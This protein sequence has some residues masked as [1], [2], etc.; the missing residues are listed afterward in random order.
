VS[1]RH[2]VLIVALVAI[3]IAILIWQRG[4]GTPTSSKTTAERERVAKV[5]RGSAGDA[6]LAWYARGARRRIAGVVLDETKP[7]A[8]ATVRLASR[9]AMAGVMPELR[10]VS[11][12]NGRFEFPPQLPLEYLVSAELPQRTTAFASVDL[13]SPASAEDLHLVLHACEA[14]LHGTIR[15]AAGGVI[16]HARVALAE[17]ELSTSA[18]AEADDGGKYELCVPVGAAIVIASADGYADAVDY[19]TA[20]GPVQRDFSLVPEATVAGKVVLATDRSPVANAVVELRAEGR[21]DRP[22]RTR[23]AVSDASGAFHFD[24]ATPGSYAIIAKADGLVSTR[25]TYVIAEAEAPLEDIVCVVGPSATVSGKVVERGGKPVAGSVLVLRPIAIEHAAMLAQH[26]A[27]TEP[28]GTFAIEHVLPGTYAPWVTLGDL[29]DDAKRIVVV[30]ADVSNVVLEIERGG[31]ISGRVTSRGKPVEGAQVNV[32]GASTVRFTESDHAGAFVLDGLGEG[33]LQLYA[34]SRRAGAFTTNQQIVL[35]KGERKTGIEIDMN[36][37]GSIAGVVVDQNDKPVPGAVLRFSLLRGADYGIATTA[38]DGTFVANALSGGGEYAYEVRPNESSAV[39]YRPADRKRFAPIAVADG[40]AQITGVRI[41][42]QREDLAIAGRVLDAGGEPAAGVSIAVHPRTSHDFTL[43]DATGAFA[44]RGLPAGTYNVIAK[45]ARG[46]AHEA[47]V[48]AGRSDV[49]LRFKASGEIAGTLEGFSGEVDVSTEGANRYRITAEK[50]FR[51]RNVP[52]GRY[53]IVA[54]AK[55]GIAQETVV[56]KPGETLEVVLRPRGYG[57]LVGTFVDA[58]TREPIENARC[59]IWT[60]TGQALQAKTD[61]QGR[62]RF[63][64]VIAGPVNIECSSTPGTI[65]V[66]ANQE[67]RLDLAQKPTKHTGRVFAGMAL[68][69]QLGDILVSEVMANRPAAKAGLMVGD[70][71]VAIDGTHLEYEDPR[72]VMMIIEARP[73][74]PMK[75]TI[76][77]GEKQLEVTLVLE[78]GP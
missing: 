70:I 6:P 23:V 39:V 28:N 76:D 29:V 15:D 25:P 41:R 66:V 30:S 75:L 62:Y 19:L 8:G 26:R 21:D 53:V 34:E 43:T 46:E 69:N 36:L 12:A 13:R 9:L 51:L 58:T 22:V 48:K 5:K 61:A 40:K 10:V 57:A 33:T 45:T 24:G 56:V 4:D 14:S 64:K 3:G 47:N 2:V 31:S 63:E 16:P 32:R 35:G 44:I 67:A 42:V 38:R 55:S 60:S 68:E 71:L 74:G 1:R 20:S 11:D 65:E 49:V 50:S 77:R 18:G 54:M 52:S 37:A 59:D 73:P 7:V 78:A 27:V 17:G 72:H